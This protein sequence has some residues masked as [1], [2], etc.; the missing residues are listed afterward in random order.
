MWSKGGGGGIA[1]ISSLR[2]TW[3]I[4]VCVVTEAFLIEDTIFLTISQGKKGWGG[5]CGQK[6]G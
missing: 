3:Y 1:S 6:G 4:G 2:H 5:I